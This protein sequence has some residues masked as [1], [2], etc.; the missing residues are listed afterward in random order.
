MDKAKWA[1]KLRLF[2]SADLAGSTA[3]KARRPDAIAPEWAPTFRE[4]FMEFPAAVE[5][6]YARVPEKATSPAMHL[7]PWKFSGD[8]AIFCVELANHTEV[9][10]HLAA[11]KQAITAFAIKWKDQPLRL[12]GAAWLAGFPVSNVEL[13]IESINGKMI[14]FI[15]PAMDR[16][17]RVA[18]FAD[19]RRFVLTPDLVLMLI[20]ALDRTEVGPANKEF[21]VFYAGRETLKGVIGNEPFPIFWL[22]MLNGHRTEEDLLLG[23]KRDDVTNAAKTFLR[24]FLDSTPQL[25]RPFIDGDPDE[26]YGKIPDFINDHREKMVAEETQRGYVDRGEIEQFSAEGELKLSAPKPSEESV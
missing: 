4:F 23:L 12:K 17:F 15:G 13:E 1:W 24:R 9:V 5:A 25:M 20:D 16:G 11:F 14:D 26:K 19:I 18:K 3:F 8:E 6:E 7:M 22:D 10:A 21:S 2:A